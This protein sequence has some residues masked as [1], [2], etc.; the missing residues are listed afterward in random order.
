MIFIKG[1][2]QKDTMSDLQK[3][4][5]KSERMARAVII[6]VVVV[7]SG[8]IC[9]MYWAART[10]KNAH[11]KN[12]EKVVNSKTNSVMTADTLN[13]TAYIPRIQDFQKTR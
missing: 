13:T 10:L 9:S 8:Y 6:A 1:N 12:I 7:A 3:E 11:L 5:I 2:N 4:F